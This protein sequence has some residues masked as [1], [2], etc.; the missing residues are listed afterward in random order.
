MLLIVLTLLLFLLQPKQ[1]EAVAVAVKKEEGGSE[2]GASGVGPVSAAEGNLRAATGAAPPSTGKGDSV[3][4]VPALVASLVRLAEAPPILPPPPAKGGD[5]SG[6]ARPKKEEVED[7]TMDIDGGDARAPNAEEDERQEAQYA[8][9]DLADLSRSAASVASR[10]DALR[11][12]LV[13]LL[14]NAL[15]S[16]SATVDKLSAVDPLLEPSSLRRDIAA[17]QNQ[18]GEKESKLAELTFA[19]DE[20]AQGERRV[21]RGLYRLASGRMKLSDVIKVCVCA[22]ASSTL[23]GPL[24][25]HVLA[26]VVC[27]AD[28]SVCCAKTYNFDFVGERIVHF[29]VSGHYCLY[30]LLSF[31]VLTRGIF[32]C[33]GGGNG[34]RFGSVPGVRQGGGI[35]VSCSAFFACC[36]GFGFGFGG[37][38][39]GC[40]RWRC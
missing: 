18:L 8:K 20:A 35:D 9:A 38:Y 13:P 39:A 37:V 24:S 21:R 23:I 31:P 26:L 36:S 15:A 34:G 3:E 22:R 16:A 2:A 33:V 27:F 17:L 32:L 40:G 19:R 29:A 11:N 30:G 28:R 1:P 14:R 5:S 6:S 12:A 10:A 7:D 25:R 4:T